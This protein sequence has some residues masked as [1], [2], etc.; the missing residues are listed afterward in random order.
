MSISKTHGKLLTP[1][2]WVWTVYPPPTKRDL[3]RFDPPP[4]IPIG[5]QI[6]AYTYSCPY[7]IIFMCISYYFVY[8]NRQA[9]YYWTKWWQNMSLEGNKIAYTWRE[10][11]QI[12]QKDISWRATSSVRCVKKYYPPPSKVIQMLTPKWVPQLLTL[13]FNLLAPSLN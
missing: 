1:I 10:I 4:L 7:L 5:T 6:H 8:C 12:F 11:L 3:K 2:R 9:H 13:M